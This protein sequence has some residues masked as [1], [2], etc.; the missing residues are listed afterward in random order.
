MMNEPAQLGSARPT[1]HIVAASRVRFRPG[2][3]LSQRQHVAVEVPVNLGLVWVL[4]RQF[5]VAGAAWSYTLRT[6]VETIALWILV[7]RMVPLPLVALIQARLLPLGALVSLMCIAA[8]LIE[9][10]HGGIASLA[11]TLAVLCAYGVAVLVFLVDE[12]DRALFDRIRSRVPG[13]RSAAAR[14]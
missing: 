9:T 2:A 7:R 5:G 3:S 10:Q 14:D 11:M 13:L 8:A 1:S 4:T 6:I 12:S